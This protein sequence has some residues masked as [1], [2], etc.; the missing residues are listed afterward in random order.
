MDIS[1]RN[2]LFLMLFVMAAAGFFV[3]QVWKQNEY[4]RLTKQNRTVCIQL[5][6]IQGDIAN[7][8]IDNKRL[9]DYKRLEKLA[10]NEYG[11]VFAGVPEFIESAKR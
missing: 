6:K 4:V 3:V 9:K 11:L 7:I 2:I 8:M 5:E 1:I 10:R